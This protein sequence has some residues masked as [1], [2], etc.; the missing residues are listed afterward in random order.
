MIRRREAV[1]AR[2]T[3]PQLECSTLSDAILGV[4]STL[5]RSVDFLNRPHFLVRESGK[6]RSLADGTRCEIVTMTLNTPTLPGPNTAEPRQKTAQE[7]AKNRSRRRWWLWLLVLG[8][9]GW[10]GSRL[11]E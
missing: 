9:L 4:V 7:S 8:L 11:L 6:G 5:S 3:R 2:G 10:S 1:V